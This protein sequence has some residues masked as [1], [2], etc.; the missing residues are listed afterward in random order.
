MEGGRE[1]PKQ[2]R[3]KVVDKTRRNLEKAE[4]AFLVV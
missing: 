1:S 4:E 3:K 2:K